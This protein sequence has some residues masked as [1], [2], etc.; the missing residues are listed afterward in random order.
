[1]AKDTVIG[2]INFGNK[3]PRGND[4]DLTTKLFL[5]ENQVS[6][7]GRQIADI[8]KKINKCKKRKEK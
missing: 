6:K 7:Q 1:M 2:K 5:L 8:L 3:I 4:G